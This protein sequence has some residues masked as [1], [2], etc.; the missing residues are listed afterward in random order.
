MS[1]S[2]ARSSLRSYRAYNAVTPWN[3]HPRL[4]R[5]GLDDAGGATRATEDARNDLY[6]LPAE[7]FEAI[8]AQ[9]LNAAQLMR[10]GSSCKRLSNLVLYGLPEIWFRLSL[11]NFSA[12]DLLSC[13]FGQSVFDAAAAGSG[14]ESRRIYQ[15]L[16]RRCVCRQCGE[17]FSAGACRG[18]KRHTGVL[19]SGHRTNGIHATWTCC[20]SGA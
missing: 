8:V 20:G 12:D 15:A 1:P 9:D 6:R 11:A 14:A 17:N 4:L 7:L 5:A 10:V 3:P 16:C 19:I 2:S 18:C 13:P